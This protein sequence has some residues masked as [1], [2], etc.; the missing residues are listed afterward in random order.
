[1]LSSLGAPLVPTIAQTDHVSLGTA[2]WVLTIGLLSGALTTPVM[3]RLADGPRQRQVVIVTLVVGL[4]GC[5][6]TALSTN[7][8]TL[9]VGR[10]LQGTGLGMLPVTMAIARAH[11]PLEKA[12][13]A[14]VSLSITTAVGTG[15]GYPVT[16]L[17]AEV[18]DFH[19]AFWFG[20]MAIGVALLAA[21][22][23][24]PPPPVVA[25]RRFDWIGVVGLTLAVTSLLVVLSEGPVWGWASARV[26][27]LLTGSAFLLAV[28][29]P[30]ELRLEDP[31]VE[32]RLVRRRRVLTADVSGLFVSTAMY[33]YIPLVVEM[34]QL[35]SSTGYGFGESIAVAG[36]VQVPQAVGSF[37]TSRFVTGLDRRFGPRALLPVGSLIFAAVIVFVT[38]E[39]NHLWEMF[40]ALG[41]S[42]I[43]VGLTFGAMPGLIVRAVP[44]SE[45][46]SATGFYMVVRSI[47]LS[48]G[49]AIAAAVLAA[50]TPPG[51]SLPTFAGFRTALLIGAGLCVATAIV[52]YV[53]PGPAGRPP[54]PGPND[55]DEVMAAGEIEFGSTEV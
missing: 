31:L 54:R 21:V 37:V 45:T 40:I 3:G 28:W 55:P 25:P 24:V 41:I 34:V 19:A 32:L 38:V 48:L 6:V 27:A 36:L 5:V 18:F 46:G 35:P 26:L 1:V 43:G 39:H 23:V 15:L 49:S 51:H 9:I 7:F 50:H 11:L 13:R 44:K 12:S 47:G 14:V 29:V 33:L 10:A 52:S 53:L 30:H 20:A 2:Q 17:I 4:I 42:G 22:L 8:A 16:S